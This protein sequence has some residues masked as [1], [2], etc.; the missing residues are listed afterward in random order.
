MVVKKPK[1]WN[2]QKPENTRR[3]IASGKDGRKKPS[4]PRLPNTM[5]KV[6]DRLNTRSPVD[7]D[8]EENE[9]KI[10]T[11]ENSESVG[12]DIYEYEEEV[13]QEELGKNRRFDSVENLNYELPDDFEDEDIPSDD[14]DT[15][16]DGD[17]DDQA[18]TGFNAESEED[19]GRHA[20]MLQGIT[21]MP[22]EAFE[23]RKKS[24]GNMVSVTRP[25]SE[26][27]PS[28]NVLDGDNQITIQ[29]LLDPLQGKAGYNQLRKRMH[30]LEKK[31]VPIQAPLSKPEKEKVERK[32]A[33][34]ISKKEIRKWEPL[35]KR[36][37]EAP[38][39]YF[40][41]DRDLK[42]STVG[43]IASRF[44]PRTEFEKKMHSL[45]SDKK[46]LEAHANDGTRLLELNMISVED[47]KE[48]RDRIAKIRNLLS[49]HEIKQKHIKKIKSKTYHRL[50]KKDRLKALSAQMEMDPEAANEQARKQEFKR[51]EERLT[52]KHK[53]NSKWAKRILKR[54]LDA[55]DEGTRAAISEQ[56]QQ[57]ETLTRK[58]NSMKDA[59]SSDDSS[60]GDDEDSAD[61]E[62]DAALKL[63]EDAREKT[64]KVLEVDDA[65][66]SSGVF[67]LPFMVRGL[68][69]RREAAIEEAK[70][71]L[72]D[73][74][75]LSKQM[76]DSQEAGNN[77]IGVS[78]GRMTFGVVKP[79]T[80]N[81]KR[82]QRF[83][84]DSDTGD[85]IDVKEDGD[86]G[87]QYK[88]NI[89]IGI[90]N[91][92]I[93][94]DEDS[95][96]HKDSI[97]KSFDSTH[98]DPDDKATYEVSIFASD[99]WMKMKDGKKNVNEELSS[100]K[101]KVVKSS[102]HNN[103][104]KEL[105]EESDTESEG[106]MVDGILSAGPTRPYELPSQAELVRQAFAGDDVE[107]DFEKDKKEI[108]N[109]ENPEP[110]KPVFLPG[111]GEWVDV[112]KKKGLPS[113][114]LKEHND[115]KK[116]RE[117]ALKKRKDACLKH[118]I[119]SEKVDKKAE[120]LFTKVLPFPFTS[121]EAFEQSMRVPLGPEF[122]PAT[123]INDLIRPEVVKKPGINIKPIK[124]EEVNPHAKDEDQQ[125]SKQKMT[126]NKR[127]RR[128]GGKVVNKKAK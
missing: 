32:V 36:N 66:P 108:L 113:W 128:G 109:E 96:A 94:F 83:H 84:D 92:S 59:S 88:E 86:N 89:Q 120:K 49:R 29:D 116:K 126:D 81:N 19:L 91:D 51:A 61:S 3:F 65:I 122:H 38:T 111:W 107:E 45:V 93:L 23:G 47:E 31:S 124:F 53:N 40:D 73:Y 125:D 98:E 114:M 95:H 118:V 63:I 46:V 123:A 42:Y 39:L 16:D 97:F 26:F 101:N 87:R 52:L 77:S 69:K 18:K 67:S 117:E 28:H 85:D 100:Q 76:D 48:R 2:S 103:H 37:R 62:Q 21:G 20:R 30:H 25:E 57:H 17:K 121:E 75:K 34:A 4:G 127:K 119:I 5:K 50:L 106:Q 60:D 11:E 58:I 13:A 70:L 14:E 56:L 115:A 105:I 43:A 78:S 54:G 55:Q 9:V 44:E 10:D 90:R 7:S 74:E 79:Q 71:A 22:I 104:L 24:K 72:E 64:V 102:S 27:N 41:E 1:D 35:V 82:E 112:Q 15:D 33:Y 12:N 8:G 6:L 80:E 99:S 68:K 110:E